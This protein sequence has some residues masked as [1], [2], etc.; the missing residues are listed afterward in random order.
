MDEL[1]H[2]ACQFLEILRASSF[3]RYHT[4]L[5]G[6]GLTKWQYEGRQ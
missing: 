5:F 3:A 6:S 4:M 2:I 1:Q